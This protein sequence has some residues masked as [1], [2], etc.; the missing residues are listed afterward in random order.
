MIFEE[1]FNRRCM[2]YYTAKAF[3]GE[4]LILQIHQS[5]NAWG[6]RLVDI[7]HSDAINRPTQIAFVKISNPQRIYI[8]GMY[9][10]RV[11]MHVNLSKDEQRDTKI[12]GNFQGFSNIISQMCV[13][14]HVQMCLLQ[15]VYQL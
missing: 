10:Y 5:E 6:K 2:Y 4:K 8:L 13:Y 15:F 3:R 14:V 7:G 9:I 12:A 11:A 1:I